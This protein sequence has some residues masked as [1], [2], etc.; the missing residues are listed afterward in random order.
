MGGGDEEF[1]KHLNNITGCGLR[2]DE[3]SGRR[4]QIQIAQ[5]LRQVIAMKLPPRECRAQ[6]VRSARK[7]FYREEYLTFSMLNRLNVLIKEIPSQ[8]G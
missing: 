5:C 2:D 6:E 8:V 4:R 1:V 3:K 7:T